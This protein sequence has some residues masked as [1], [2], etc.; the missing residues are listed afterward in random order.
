MDCD[1]EEALKAKETAERK[2]NNK[3]VKGAKKLALKA[4]NLFPSLEGISQMITT[5]DVYL[6]A[7]KKINGESDWYA[8]LSVD[9]TADEETLKKHYRQLALQLHPDKNKSVG[10]EGAFKLISEAWNVFSDKNRKMAYD[11]MRN[12]DGL[13]NRASQPHRDCSVH[14]TVNGFYSSSNT[15]SGKRARKRKTGSAPSAAPPQPHPI[16]LNTFWTSCN[17]CRMQ[18][19]YLRT[20]LNHNLLCPNCHQAFMAIEIG[21]PGNAANS[22]ISWSARQHEHNSNYKYTI[23]N[24]YSSGFSTS[25]FSGTGHTELQHGGNLDFYNHHKFQWSSFTGSSGTSSTTDSAF[26]PANLIHKK[27]GKKRRKHEAQAAAR[28]EESFRTDYH[29]YKSADDGSRNY[30]DGHTLT[31]YDQDQCISKAGR[32]AKRRNNGD[33]S[34]DCYRTDETENMSTSIEDT[35][36]PEVERSNGAVED[37]L[38]TRMTARQNNYIREYSQV[39]IWKMLTE[40]AKAA[41]GIKL[42]EWNLA[43]ANK[44]EEKEKLRRQNGQEASA[45]DANTGKHDSSIRESSAHG[46]DVNTAK[47]VVKHVSIDVPDP[48]FYDFDKDR[49]EM[50]FEGDQVWATYD[51]EDGMPRLYAMVQKVLSLNPFNIRMSFLNTKSNSELGPVNWVASG[52]DKTCGDFRVGRY[53]ISDTVNIF[54]HRVRWEKGPRG[55]IRIVPKKG[56]IWALYRNWSPDWNEL[57]PDDV[58]YKYEMVEVLDDYTDDHGVSVIPLV[59]VAGFKAVFHRHMDP[60]E[61]KRITREEMFRF[62]HQVPSY[63]LTGEEAHNALKGCLELDPAATPVELLQVIT[64]VKE[65]LGMEI[66]KQQSGN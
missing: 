48:D 58:I 49:L 6:A 65:N 45:I 32:P 29:V 54:S 10:A 27:F 42:E 8:I 61:V 55:V 37:L 18:Y 12:V 50:T 4:Q 19:E 62:S 28:R 52:F 14:N 46:L 43:Q 66:N 9:A 35:I 21:I 23:K 34:G 1:R 36:N 3:D 5:L 15:T 20:Y 41:I 51:S 44:L 25:T 7:G 26:Q 64:K 33:Q 47:K 30:N 16:N 40:K 24:G 59:K 22:S 13:E 60:L 2:F 11:Q 17:C 38:R 63:L 31:S 39:N 57:T 56:D 53:Q